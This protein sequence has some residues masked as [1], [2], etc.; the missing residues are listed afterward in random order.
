MNDLRL[1]NIDQL[2][3]WKGDALGGT[4]PMSDR[5][6]MEEM[7]RQGMQVSDG[8]EGL[9]GAPGAVDPAAAK[10]GMTDGFA[11][12]LQRT[13]ENVNSTQVQAD[14][15]MKELIA[16]RTKNVHETMLAVEKAEMSLKLMM[17]VRNKVLDAYREIM[18]MQ[19]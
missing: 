14:S 7:R 10:G 18:R 12:M 11:Q 4:S 16:G 2:S 17:Q 1:E 15:A 13:L 5:R 19:V 8:L 3:G 6:V 9:M